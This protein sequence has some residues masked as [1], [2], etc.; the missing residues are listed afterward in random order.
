MQVYDA[1]LA[2]AS[3]SCRNETIAPKQDILILGMPCAQSK[4]VL[5][6]ILSRQ[7]N[8][9]EALIRSSFHE[10]LRLGGTHNGD[11]VT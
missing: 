4:H 3:R 6:A 10:L 2:A 9:R 1:V 8:S 11:L 5:C 7:H